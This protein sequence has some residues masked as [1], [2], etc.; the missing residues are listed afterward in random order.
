[1]A[2]GLQ[3]GA[4]EEENTPREGLLDKIL[5]WRGR[6]GD[7]AQAQLAEIISDHGDPDFVLDD[8]EKSLVRNILNLRDRTV[9]DVMVPRADIVAVSNDTPLQEI[10]RVVSEEGHSRLPVYKDTLDDAQGM[11][12]V[13]DV[14][15][16]RGRDD[17]FRTSKI[18]RRLLF[19]APSMR[20][21]ELMLEMRV[22][23]QHMALVVDEFGGVDGLV[24]IEDLVEEIV[25]EIEDEHDNSDEPILESRGEDTF[26]AEA[27]TSVE[28]LE[29][30]FG[31]TLSEEERDE[32]DTLGGLVFMLAG[33]VP[34]RGELIRHESGLEFEILE[35]NPRL[36]R[37]LLIRRTEPNSEPEA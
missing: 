6:N 22:T 21:M 19:V 34:I 7:S 10:I 31:E 24:T 14:L 13:R 5:P 11:V 15:A 25:G 4:G 2:S 33:R 28:A 27:R 36:V 3:I 20:V 9:E 23:R 32:V 8:E 37:T 29:E 35:A 18:Q 17:D 1:M 16:W 12:H 26:F 30:V